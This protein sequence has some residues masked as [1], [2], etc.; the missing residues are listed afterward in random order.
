MTELVEV[1]ILLDIV[2][3]LKVIIRFQSISL[4]NI[5]YEAVRVLQM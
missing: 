4:C 1:I 5:P 3:I 2:D